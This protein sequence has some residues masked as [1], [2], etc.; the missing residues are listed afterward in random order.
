MVYKYKLFSFSILSVL[1]AKNVGYSY[2]YHHVKY[3]SDSSPESHS[4]FH[5]IPTYVHNSIPSHPILCI[6]LC[7]HKVSS[8]PLNCIDGIRLSCVQIILCRY[9]AVTCN[10]E[11]LDENLATFFTQGK[12][13]CLEI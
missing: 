13:I 6:I 3:K 1:I 8:Q 7:Y 4:G 2:S 11:C 10:Y 12:F 9:V 5:R